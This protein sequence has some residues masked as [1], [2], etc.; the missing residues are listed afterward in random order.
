MLPQ[1]LNDLDHNGDKLVI[2][3]RMHPKQ[4]LNPTDYKDQN[5]LMDH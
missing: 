3:S 5:A 4:T 1:F 2:P